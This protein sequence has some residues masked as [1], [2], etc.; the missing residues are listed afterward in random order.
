MTAVDA[1][2]AGVQPPGPK[3]A[4]RSRGKLLAL[5]VATALVLYLCFLIVAPFL[6]PIIWA[7]TIAVVTHRFARWVRARVETPGRQAAICTATV[8]VAILLPIAVLTYVAIGQVGAAVAELQSE[9]TQK[10]MQAWLKANPRIEQ[11]WN[12]VSDG[13]NPAEKIPELLERLRP[14]AMAA[15][16]M[17]LYV[18]LQ[19]V[20]MLYVL[21]FLY[22]DERRAIDSLRWMLP[23]TEA[24]SDRLL[25][26][27]GDTLNATIYG[28]MT[29]AVTQGVAGGLMMAVLGVPAAVLWGVVMAFVAIIPTGTFTVWGPA[30]AYLA[31]QGEWVR[32]GILLGWGALAIGLIDNFL[33][34]VLVGQRL[35]QHTVVTFI[36]IVGG[37]SLFGLTGV[38]LG[39][40]IVA[41]TFFL[42]ELWRR[43]TEHGAS[44]ERV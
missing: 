41:V 26:R 10:Q 43:R 38:V 44:A 7:T 23:L 15:I 31:L 30:T 18:A 22:R 12:E 20:I 34:P 2:L 21:F 4:T 14:G 29:V 9:E 19:L 36:A 28:T 8:A 32:A 5:A 40:V 25:S 1:P 11:A 24:E 33:Y 42:L 6:A 39:P 16:S 3:L 27:V 13:F 37:L 17:P 35:H